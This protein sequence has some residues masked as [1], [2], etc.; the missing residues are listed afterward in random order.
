MAVRTRSWVRRMFLA[1]LGMCE[2]NTMK[3]YRHQVGPVTRYKW[4]VML[5]DKLINNPWITDEPVANDRAN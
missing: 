2:T 1:I 5:S 4:L 3:A